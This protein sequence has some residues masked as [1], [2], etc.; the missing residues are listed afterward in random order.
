MILG[1]IERQYAHFPV[2]ATLAD[3]APADLADV[4]VALVPRSAAPRADTTWTPVEKTP[5]Y[6]LLHENGDVLSSHDTFAEALTAWEDAPPRSRIAIRYSLLLAGPDAETVDDALTV[7]DDGAELWVRV[8]D[9]P[10]VDTVKV[11]RV[12]VS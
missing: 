11:E 2:T 10:E 6:L 4:A 3:G 5:G 1:R 9:S 7:P 8:L 12:Q